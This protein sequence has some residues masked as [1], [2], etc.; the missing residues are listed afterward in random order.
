MF[1]YAPKLKPWYEALDGAYKRLLMGGLILAVSAG[2]FGLSC[3]YPAIL[4]EG[5]VLQCTQ[6]SA[7]ELI[8]ITFAA[9]AANVATFTLAVRPTAKPAA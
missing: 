7:N 4:P 6:A 2:A 9:L 8:K 3:Y 1:G 5:W